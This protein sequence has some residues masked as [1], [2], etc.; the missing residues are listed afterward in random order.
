MERRTKGQEAVERL[1][2]RAVERSGEGL[3]SG[4]NERVFIQN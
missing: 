4:N 2:K 1:G 3:Q